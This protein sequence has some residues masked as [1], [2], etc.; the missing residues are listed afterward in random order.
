MKAWIGNAFLILFLFGI[1][2][3]SVLLVMQFASAM[4]A[5]AFN[6]TPIIANTIANQQS[7][8][9]AQNFRLFDQMIP[10]LII[11]LLIVDLILSGFLNANPAI[12]GLGLVAM[13]MLTFASF[14]VANAVQILVSQP[15]FANVVALDPNTL[16]LDANIPMYTTLFTGGYLLVIL[17]RFFNVRGIN[18]TLNKA[19]LPFAIFQPPSE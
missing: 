9:V 16:N 11:G 3:T 7:Q 17:L 5:H 14:Y 12:W 6:Q 2:F 4:L 19:A 1:L 8:Q 13:I 15:V 18:D 10:F